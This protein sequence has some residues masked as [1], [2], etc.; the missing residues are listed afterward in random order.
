MVASLDC[1]MSVMQREGD[2]AVNPRDGFIA[3]AKNCA[4]SGSNQTEAVPSRLNHPY[5]VMSINFAKFLDALQMRD[6]NE[7]RRP[8]T[9][10]AVVQ[11]TATHPQIRSILTRKSL[12][13]IRA[14]SPTREVASTTPKLV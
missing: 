12:M 13:N 8:R 1:L 5:G 4:C 7:Q 3:V 11:G 10:S 9:N 2:T 6:L 14:R